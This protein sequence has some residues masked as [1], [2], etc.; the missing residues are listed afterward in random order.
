MRRSTRRATSLGRCLRTFLTLCSTQ[1]AMTGWSNTALM[2]GGRA[3]DPSMTKSVGFLTSRPRSRSP[4]RRRA[5]HDRGVLGVA[6]HERQR[7]L[8]AV[9]GDAEGHDAQM[10]AEI[11]PVDPEPVKHFETRSYEA[12]CCVS[13]M[14]SLIHATVGSL[15]GWGRRPPN[16]VGLAA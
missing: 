14:G 1:R 4:T 15:G 16:R 6:L 3:L 9:D 5:L 8:G 13:S 12:F 2:A 7:V 11:G 10:I